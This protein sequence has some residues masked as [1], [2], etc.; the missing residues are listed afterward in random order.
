MITVHLA[1]QT[2]PREYR[3]VLKPSPPWAAPG[4]IGIS[5]HH[6]KKAVVDR[7][8][9]GPGTGCASSAPITALP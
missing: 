3:S 1:P 6:V 4:R 9:L 5:G 8:Q 2:P 7:I